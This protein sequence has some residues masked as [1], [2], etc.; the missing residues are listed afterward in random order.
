MG[1]VEGVIKERGM[2][3]GGRVEEE[4]EERRERREEERG[5]RTDEGA[6][7]S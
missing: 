3:E 6:K 2:A 4:G 7:G 5:K 1:R